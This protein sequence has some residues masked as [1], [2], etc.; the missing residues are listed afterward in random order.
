VT[1]ATCPSS[2]VIFSGGWNV[3]DIALLLFMCVVVMIFVVC[4]TL[5]RLTSHFATRLPEIFFVGGT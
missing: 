2:E 4:D 3:Y 1:V 5:V